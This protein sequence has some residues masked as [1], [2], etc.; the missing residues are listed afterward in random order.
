MLDLSTFLGSCHQFILLSDTE[1]TKHEGRLCLQHHIG[2]SM[3]DIS[4]ADGARIKDSARAI[5]ASGSL[6]PTSHLS[7][8]VRRT[9]C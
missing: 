7:W 4:L 2:V 5:V 1:N 6:V 8:Q 9:G 3:R